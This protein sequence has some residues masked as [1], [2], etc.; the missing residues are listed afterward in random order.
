MKPKKPIKRLPGQPKLRARWP[1]LFWIYLLVLALFFIFPGINYSSPAEISWQQFEKDMLSRKAVEK[2]TV[3]NNEK[4]DVYIKKEFANDK[5][6]KKVFD[7]GDVKEL[8]KGPHYRFTIGSPEI[9][10]RK[11]D[12]AEKNF[13][14]AEKVPVNYVKETNYIG[15]MISWILP[16]L[17]ISGFLY[18][19]MRRSGA[20]GQGEGSIFNF[21]KTTATLFGKENS[22]VTFKDVA[23]LEDA[24]M[25][26]R[27]IVDFL[28]NPEV[29]TRL[30]A[31]IPKG[32]ILVGP[33]GT[34]KT[35]L[36]KAVAGEARVP[37]FSI[38]GSEFVEMF[39]GVGASRVRD[40]FKRAKEKA[41]CIIFIDEID[42]IGR[43]RGKGAFLTGS[44]DE[45]ES[46]LNQLLTEMDGFG[47]NNGVIVLA[48]SNRADILDP[49]LLRPGRFDRHI[50]LELPNLTEREAIFKVHLRPIITDTSVDVHFLATQTPGF[51][52]ADIANI[53]NESALIAARKKETTVNK[54]D[55]ADA[56]DRVVAG[57][58][59]KGKIISPEEKK[60]IAYHEAGHAIASWFLKSVDPLIKVSIIPRGKSLGAAWYLPEEKQLIR[61]SAFYENLCAALGGRAA[62]DVI[63]GEVSSGA[64]DDLEKATKVAYT[65]VAYYGF[66]Q[67][68][69]NTSYY[70]STGQRDTSFQKPFSEETGKLID[71]EVRKLVDEAYIETKE[72]L[73]QKKQ[74]LINIAELLLKKEV[75]YKD[76]LEGVL[77]KRE[78]G[79]PVWPSKTVKGSAI[80]S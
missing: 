29:Y 27:E 60:T 71:Q 38:S 78:G 12:E 69:G 35:L 44:N 17:L 55:F 41:P 42:A 62:E 13:S 70:D 5:Y 20:M 14:V 33:P 53:C 64:L 18:F 9:F 68:L 63:F 73:V 47:T 43:S 45:R 8:S 56:I 61:K 58:E 34:G 79:L 3:I 80:I 1:A 19:L 65:M 48:A 28:K 37:F 36:A 7:T 2:L 32:A 40:L 77:G 21:G 66:N 16:F 59:K 23:G 57:S 22:A 10:E 31:K 50:Y 49:A 25:E 54:Q 76:D 51:S 74:F 72:L 52:G 11:L 4:V 39:V 26:V 24:Q 75:I 30:G 6:F 67:K 15:N 46:T